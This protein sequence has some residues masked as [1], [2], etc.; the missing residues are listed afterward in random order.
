M[1]CL[2]LNLFVPN[3]RLN[4]LFL[5]V[6]NEDLDSTW[7]PRQ[8]I[9]DRLRHIGLFVARLRVTWHMTCPV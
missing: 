7:D 2:K 5:G 8:Q 3:M 4:M 1:T 6:D 9:S